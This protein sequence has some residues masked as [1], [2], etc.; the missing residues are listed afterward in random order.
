M[1]PVPRSAS[2]PLA[3]MRKMSKLRFIEV[4][5]FVVGSCGLRDG[6]RPFLCN[7]CSGCRRDVPFAR[8]PDRG[9]A[10]AAKVLSSSARRMTLA[11]VRRSRV[12][13]RCVAGCH[14]QLVSLGRGACTPPAARR[15]ARECDRVRARQSEVIMGT[16]GKTEGQNIGQAQGSQ[17]VQSQ[18]SQGMSVGSPIANEAYNVIAALHAKLE[19]LE[20]YRKYAEDG[21]AQLWQSLTQSE[22]QG[23]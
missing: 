21:P 15:I 23:V 20:A 16:A 4:L 7:G 5:L 9:R 19:G 12:S 2:T 18:G 1:R 13:P 6:G 22:V 3:D 17:N 10:F 8:A 14:V 11:A